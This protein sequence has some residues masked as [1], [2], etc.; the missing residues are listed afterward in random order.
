M[1][2]WSPEQLAAGMKILGDGINQLKP[3]SNRTVAIMALTML[4]AVATGRFIS[5][6]EW[7]HVLEGHFEEKD[8]VHG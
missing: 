4:A 3:G 5:T 8:D 6:N 1:T 7:P 2:A